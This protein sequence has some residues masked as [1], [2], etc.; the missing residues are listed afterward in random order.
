MWRESY[1]WFGY[2]AQLEWR[3]HIE[4][5]EGTLQTQLN[6]C[7]LIEIFLNLDFILIMNKFKTY[8]GDILLA[9]NPFKQLGIYNLQVRINL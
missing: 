5:L 4:S 7:K 8:I 3:D 6:I 9:I 1:Q 2:F